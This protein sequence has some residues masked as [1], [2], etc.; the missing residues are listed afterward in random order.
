[1]SIAVK[2]IFG[3]ILALIMVG[4]I[5]ALA[6]LVMAFIYCKTG[7]EILFDIDIRNEKKEEK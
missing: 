5:V 6:I 4:G 1:M 3:I 2:I 7:G